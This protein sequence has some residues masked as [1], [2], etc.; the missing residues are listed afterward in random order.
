MKINKTDL[1]NAFDIVKAAVGKNEI[2]GSR[3]DY[4]IKDG[5]LIA[6]NGEVVAKTKIN[7]EDNLVLPGKVVALV[8]ALTGEDITISGNNENVKISS[9]KARNIYKTTSVESYVLPKVTNNNTQIVEIEAKSLIEAINLVA[10]AIPKSSTRPILT[11]MN[12]KCD[13]G[14]LNFAGMDG[15]RVAWFKAKTESNEYWDI[16]IPK[17]CIEIVKSAEF[18]SNVKIAFNS[19]WITFA[20]DNTSISSRLLDGEYVNYQR[21]FEINNFDNFTVNTQDLIDCINRIK[22]VSDD[23]EKPKI[24]ID[25][26]NNLN[27]TLSEETVNYAEEITTDKNIDLK[28]AF[29]ANYINDAV[30]NIDG[31]VITVYT[32]GNKSPFLFVNDNDTHK[33]LVLPVSL[34]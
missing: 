33:A 12:V 24:I 11:G 25:L 3:T 6:T 29:N 4:L 13:E 18:K 7:A 19:S 27:I 15:Y 30:K 17:N 1:I 14:Y 26:S 23:R 16:T 9:G 2:G 31:N 5:Y 34:R 10:Y 21:F 8:K 20:D 22:T 28:I 32:N